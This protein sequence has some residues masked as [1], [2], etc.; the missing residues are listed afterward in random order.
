M[1]ERH[2][3]MSFNSLDRCCPTRHR[4]EFSDAVPNKP[5]KQKCLTW[6]QTILSDP[7]SDRLLRLACP[8]W[9]W[10]IMF[11]AML[12]KHTGWA[13]CSGVFFML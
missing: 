5:V 12:D 1:V 11:D 3:L 10:T 4:T 8:T 9:H 2:G 13:I 6:D 7:M